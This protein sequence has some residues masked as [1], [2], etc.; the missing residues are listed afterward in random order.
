[1][2][3]NHDKITPTHLHDD[4]K[5]DQIK[6]MF[7]D[8]APTYD[9]LNKLLSFGLDRNWRQTLIHLLLKNKPK[10]VLDMATGTADL[11]ILA[12]KKDLNINVIGLDISRE[13]I[14]IGREKVL[15]EELNERIGLYVSDGKTIPFPDHSFDSI[16]IGFGIRNFENLDQSLAELRRVLKPNGQLLIL[17]FTKNEAPLFKYFIYFYLKFIVPNIALLVSGKKSAYQYLFES[18]QHFPAHEHF[19]RILMGVGFRQVKNY[20]MSFQLCSI[21]VASK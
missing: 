10:N 1:M 2:G 9:L 12:A 13:M 21:Y 4:A 15:K 19:N 17:E 8:I 5:T 16:I 6:T 11:A 20:N 7:N 3:Y 18:I 14:E